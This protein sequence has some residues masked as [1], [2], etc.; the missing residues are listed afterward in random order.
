M[1]EAERG[2]GG[3]EAGSSPHHR[4]GQNKDMMRDVR[5]VL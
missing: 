4:P 3:R 1:A 2:E 5:C